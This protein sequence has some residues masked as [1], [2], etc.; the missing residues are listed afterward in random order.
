MLLI[1]KAG[2]TAKD[3]QA[4]PDESTGDFSLS[5]SEIVLA[6]VVE[7]IN[8]AMIIHKE[9]CN[10]DSNAITQTAEG[11]AL[12]LSNKISV[13]YGDFL[14]AKAWKDLADLHQIEVTDMMVSVLVNTTQGQFVSEQELKEVSSKLNLTY[15]LEKNFLLSAC[16]PAFGCKSVLKLASIDE[17]LQSYGYQF[18]QNLGYF[19]KAH[20]EI[21]WFLNPSPNSRDFLDFCSLP[22]VMHSLETGEPL[23]HLSRVDAIEE[24]PKLPKY[25]YNKLHSLI[26]SGPGIAKSRTV[27]EMFRANA[28]TN[29]NHFPDSEARDCLK[30]ILSAIHL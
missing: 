30:K 10:I 8:M 14:W 29:L 17:T 11:S 5:H 15:W 7:M 16:L 1:S 13:L 23:E 4:T 27:L 28:F 9:I 6:K 24:G 19:I 12:H 22:V 20:Q 25:N 26:R 21:N 18:G 3:S 2:A